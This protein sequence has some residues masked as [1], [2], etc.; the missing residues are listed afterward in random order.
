MSSDTLHIDSRY[1]G[2]LPGGKGA[3]WPYPGIGLTSFLLCAEWIAAGA[4]SLSSANSNHGRPKNSVLSNASHR[5]MLSKRS[6][7]GCV[8]PYLEMPDLWP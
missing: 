2:R 7:E 6:I 8:T 3:V 1:V 5:R 4:A